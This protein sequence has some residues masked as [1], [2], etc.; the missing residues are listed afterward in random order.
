MTEM[1]RYGNQ[2]KNDL[3]EVKMTAGAAPNQKLC[4]VERSKNGRRRTQTGGAN[5]ARGVVSFVYSVSLEKRFNLSTLL[6]V[7]ACGTFSSQFA[8]LGSKTILQPRG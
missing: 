4:L 1:C 5:F 3:K 6:I 2:R 8:A 7:F